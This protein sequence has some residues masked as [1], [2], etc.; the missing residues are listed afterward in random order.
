MIMTHVGRPKDKSGHIHA[1]PETDVESVVA[2]LERKL[3]IKLHVPQLT[4]TEG[5]GIVDIDTSI[6][7]ALRVQRLHSTALVPCFAMHALGGGIGAR[8]AH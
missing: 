3:H 4:C 2:Y 1:S 7:R 6:N 8:C 5:V